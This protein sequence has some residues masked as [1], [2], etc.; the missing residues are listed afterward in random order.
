[1]NQDHMTREQVVA[2]VL[3]YGLP[4]WI[5]PDPELVALCPFQDLRGYATTQ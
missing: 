5:T 3:R 4:W 1:M 2:F